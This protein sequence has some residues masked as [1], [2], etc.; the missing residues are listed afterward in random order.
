MILGSAANKNIPDDGI[1]LGF[2]SADCLAKFWNVFL[3]EYSLI[4]Q[5]ETL[6]QLKKSQH[7]YVE[8]PILQTIS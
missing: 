7:F 1:V 8:K 4:T 6:Q 3:R 2:P 5:A